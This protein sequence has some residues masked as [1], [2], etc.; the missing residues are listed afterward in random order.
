MAQKQPQAMHTWMGG[1]C[2]SK[3]LSQKYAADQIW[4]EGCS[5]STSGKGRLL[6]VTQ[7]PEAT[8]A[9]GENKLDV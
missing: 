2:F 9:S 6:K 8:A 4:P 3:A 5:I 7:D 1:V